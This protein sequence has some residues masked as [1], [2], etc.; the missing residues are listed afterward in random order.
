[1]IELLHNCSS[2]TI[3]Q[4]MLVAQW[5]LNVQLDH[6]M[7]ARTGW[8]V[9]GKSQSWSNHCG[10]F[11]R[12]PTILLLTVDSIDFGGEKVSPPPV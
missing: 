11:I 9:A 2:F 7:I 12:G 6:H 1:M 8:T 5:S 4:S 3:Y 10:D